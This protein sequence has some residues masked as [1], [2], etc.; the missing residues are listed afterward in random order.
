MELTSWLVGEPSVMG[1]RKS[2][3]AGI[4]ASSPAEMMAKPAAIMAQVCR[5]TR[6]LQHHG[7]L[8]FDTKR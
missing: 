2:A 4:S 5:P 3:L 6:L 1:V 8:S 7:R